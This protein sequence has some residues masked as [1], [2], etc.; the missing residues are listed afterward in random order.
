MYWIYCKIHN[1]AQRFKRMQYMDFVYPFT[2]T[3]RL[4]GIFKN[5]R[6]FK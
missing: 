1:E 6:S 2:S 4:Q 5:M 3:L